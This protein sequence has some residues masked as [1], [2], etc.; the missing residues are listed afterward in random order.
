MLIDAVVRIPDFARWP[1]LAADVVEGRQAAGRTQT[2]N[3]AWRTRGSGEC[4][5]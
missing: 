1:S 5:L 4:P 2:A 3:G